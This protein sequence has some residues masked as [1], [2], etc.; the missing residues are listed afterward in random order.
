VTSLSSLKRRRL[1]DY[2]Q[3]F[4]PG[5]LVVYVG[6]NTNFK[7]LAEFI[8]YSVAGHYC[9]IQILNGGNYHGF[10]DGVAVANLRPLN[11]IG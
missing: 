5:D 3:K 7:G 1:S 9:T 4:K 10:V 11:A 6:H 8:L 2:T